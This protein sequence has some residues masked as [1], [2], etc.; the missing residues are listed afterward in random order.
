MSEIQHTLTLPVIDGGFDQSQII[1]GVSRRF[2]DTDRDRP[3]D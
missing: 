2:H 3:H 1:F